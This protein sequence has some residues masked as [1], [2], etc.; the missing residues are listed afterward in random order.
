MAR[1]I[2]RAIFFLL[3]RAREPA[4]FW[5][6]K[7]IGVVILPGA[8]ARM[9]ISGNK[10]LMVK[11]FIINIGRIDL[12]PGELTTGESTFGRKDLLPS[13]P[14]PCECFD[15]YDDTIDCCPNVACRKYS[16]FSKSCRDLFSLL[17]SWNLGLSSK[18]FMSVWHDKKR[19][20]QG[21]LIS[22]FV[23]WL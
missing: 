15:F 23:L 5:R 16:F 6:G 8:L 2:T 3:V 19:F 1:I 4:S 9:P 11:S 10:L 13:S 21:I 7:V 18:H 22:Q 20:L 14:I 12:S 17:W